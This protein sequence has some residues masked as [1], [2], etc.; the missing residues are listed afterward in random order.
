M[1]ILELI[2]DL[3]IDYFL[4]HFCRTFKS[5]EIPAQQIELEVSDFWEVM[6]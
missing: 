1:E 3:D 6:Q 2:I 5:F 4:K